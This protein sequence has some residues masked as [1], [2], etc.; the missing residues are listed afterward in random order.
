MKVRTLQFGK[1]LSA[2][3]FVLLLNAVGLTKSFAQEWEWQTLTVNDGTDENVYVPFNGQF[4]GELPTYSQFIIPASDLTEMAWGNIRSFTFSCNYD[5]DYY[6]YYYGGFPG[7]SD[8]LFEV[9]IAEVGFDKFESSYNTFELYDWDLMTVVY[10]GG[11]SVIDHQLTIPIG[12]ETLDEWGYSFYYDYYQ[13]EGENL[14][15]GIKPISVSNNLDCSWS[16]IY[17]DGYDAWSYDSWVPSEY[18]DQTPTASLTYFRN[19]NGHE[20]VT[21][22]NQFK[23]KVTF[24]F[25]PGYVPSCLKPQNV[26]ADE[27]MIHNATISWTGEAQFFNLQYKK[28]SEEWGY[29]DSDEFGDWVWIEGGITVEGLTESQ[30]TLEGLESQTSYDVRVKAVCSAWQYGDEWYYDDVSDWSRTFTF[31]TIKPMAPTYFY[32]TDFDTSVGDSVTLRWGYNSDYYYSENWEPPTYWDIAVTT[33]LNALPDEIGY[34][35]IN[36]DSLPDYWDGY[37]YELSALVSFASYKAWIRASFGDGDISDWSGPITFMP[38]N[39]TNS[40]SVNNGNNHVT[41]ACYRVPFYSNGS[42]SRSQFI[43]PASSLTDLANHEICR[44]DFRSDYLPAF[45]KGTIEIYLTEVDEEVFTDP[46]YY[47][48]ESMHKVFDGSFDIAASYSGYTSYWWYGNAL[49]F[50]FDSPYFYEGGNLL[51]GIKASASSNGSTV[52]WDGIQTDNNTALA[53]WTGSPTQYAFLPKTTIYYSKNSCQSPHDLV[54]TVSEDDTSVTLSWVGE[55][56]NYRLCYWSQTDMTPNY[57]D[58]TGTS[59]ELTNLPR[60]TYSWSVQTLCSEDETSPFVQGPSFLNVLVREPQFHDNIYEVYTPGELI[61]VERVV[62]GTITEGTEGVFPTGNTSMEGLT[63]RLM[64]DIDLHDIKW[65]PIGYFNWDGNWGTGELYFNGT[66][67]G[68]NHIITNLYVNQPNDQGVGLFGALGSNGEI[69]SVGIEGESSITGQFNVGGVVGYSSWGSTMWNVFCNATVTG[70]EFVGGIVGYC[71][72]T[73][74]QAYFSGTVTVDATDPMEISGLGSGYSIGYCGGITGNGGNINNTYNR[75]VVTSLMG[76]AGGIS[77]GY[78]SIS[79]SYSTGV[80]SSDSGQ[81]GAIYGVGYEDNCSNNYFLEGQYDHQEGGTSKTQQYMQSNW[82]VYDLNR[83]QSPQPWKA[84]YTPNTNDGYPILQWQDLSFTVM[85]SNPEHGSLTVKNGS[86]MVSSGSRVAGGTILTVTAEPYYG[87]ILESLTANGQSINNNTLVVN[88]SVQIEAVFIPQPLGDFTSLSPADNQVITAMP[89]NFSWTPVPGA[90]RYDLYLWN[91]NDSVPNQPYVSGLTSAGYNCNT[92]E[93][94][95]TYQWYVKARN[96]AYQTTS[97][98]RNFALDAV[99]T[100]TVNPTQIYFG[101]IELNDSILRTVNVNGMALEDS[102]SVLLVGNDVEMF[103]YAMPTNW[104]PYSGGGISVTF[105]PTTMKNSYHATLIISSGALTQSVELTGSIV[106][107]F[108]FTTIVDDSIFLIGDT[109]PIHGTVKDNHNVPAANVDVE[110]GVTVFGYRR[111]LETVSD[112]NGEFAVDFIPLPFESGYYTVNSGPIGNADTTAVHDDFDILG[113]M[114]GFAGNENDSTL[115]GGYIVCEV[116]QNE[117]PKPFALPV[118]NKNSIALTNLQV[119]IVS[120]QPAG[121]VFNFGTLNL[122][123]FE[124]G[125]L[126]FTVA[127]TVPT[128]G[129]DFVEMR[130]R[131]TSDQGSQMECTILYYCHEAQAELAAYPDPIVATVTRGTSKTLDVTL[132]NNGTA[133]TGEI[134][135][136]LPGLEWMSVMGGNALPSINP[137]NSSSFTLRLSPNGDVPLGT[138]EGTIAINAGSGVSTTLHYSITVVSDDNGTLLVDVTDEFTTNTNNGNGPHVEGAEV[139]LTDYYSHETVAHGFTSSTGIF[140]AEDIPEGWYYLEVD[141]DR[142]LGYNE[143]VYISAG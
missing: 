106:N 104:N 66:F 43:I 61:W 16:G 26:E 83:G 2:A 13:Y 93:N 79:N 54:A 82:L 48:W 18:S 15:I 96:V 47:D 132:T 103:S 21:V 78:A 46:E 133:A 31:S 68:N 17:E 81:G 120:A 141:A 114:V 8:C 107:P 24:D 131:V 80:I 14:L 117:P 72:S 64:N 30:Y 76:P 86:M 56:E 97:A 55:G 113:M 32:A 100:L 112:E 98:I 92:L 139:T 115:N 136:S 118:K 45:L 9:R 1:A 109:I 6:D 38:T 11:L 59:Y 51:I 70:K 119:Q 63:V 7:W 87:Y 37:Y 10:E 110:V 4:N 89:I 121:S 36:S 58:V 44:L 101:E 12:Y 33:N 19:H 52:Y 57:V 53:S 99:P 73:I 140:G 71:G 137:N 49:A 42:Q 29:Y 84:D 60:S 123:G 77:G 69:H 108:V 111:T 22:P 62:N 5:D 40:L 125:D 94:H 34:V 88:E 74:N 122:A 134:T 85:Y 39:L 27:I 127:G 130:V 91:A 50:T 3:L 23:P 41:P 90:Q 116:T 129:Y 128:P 28:S 142:H 20:N 143:I 105:Q 135:V 95:Q 75:G 35:T 65:R 126:P 138:Y 124:E 102:L 67:D 25:E